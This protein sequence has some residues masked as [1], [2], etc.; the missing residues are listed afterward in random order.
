M[1]RDP[2][3]G[4]ESRLCAVRTRSRQPV[5]GA[6]GIVTRRARAAVAA[7]SSLV[8]WAAAACGTPSYPVPTASCNADSDCAIDDVPRDC[9]GDPCGDS[10]PW[11]AID[12]TSRDALTAARRARCEGKRL[13]CPMVNC[14]TPPACRASPV[15]VCQAGRC[16]ARVELADA[17][18]KGDCE[19]K[20]GAQPAPSPPGKERL[21][22]AGLENVWARCC[23]HAMGTSAD[24]C[25]QSG[26][27][28]VPDP[29]RSAGAQ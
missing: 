21:C 8:A 11:V 18:G 9:C 20:C 6:H 15:A 4:D 2:A 26:E 25:D 24:V 10:P 3:M 13:D 22:A 7:A 27:H 28:R 5:D 17:C 29:C 14:P 12:R 16:V 1:T 19:A 23:C